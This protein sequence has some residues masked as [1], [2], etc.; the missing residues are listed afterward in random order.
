MD[1]KKYHIDN[2]PV[3]AMELID[4]AR[5][6]DPEFDASRF[7]QTSVAARILRDSGHV[8]GVCPAEENKAS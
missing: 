8:V 2:E 7:Y 4:R 5:Q 6:L 1:V 3:S